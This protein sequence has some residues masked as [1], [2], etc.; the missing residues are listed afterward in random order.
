MVFFYSLHVVINI[1]KIDSAN[2]TVTIYKDNNLVLDAFPIDNDFTQTLTED[3]QYK[4]I[5]SSV[6]N[7]FGKTGEKVFEFDIN[8]S[9]NFSHIGL[10]I[11]VLI[12]VALSIVTGL[13]GVVFYRKKKK[14]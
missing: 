4:I 9:S 3:G 10:I 7:H 2:N 1:E 6:D 5:L 8:K 12:I 11:F 14:N 13:V